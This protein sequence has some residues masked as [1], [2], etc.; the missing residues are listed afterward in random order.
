MKI[1]RNKWK[2]ILLSIIAI[3]IIFE[4]YCLIS[5]FTKGNL[6]IYTQANSIYYNNSN[7]DVLVDVVDK[8]GKLINSKI[9]LQLY[10]NDGKKVKGAKQFLK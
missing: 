1:S 4:A 6:N 5:F 10:N 9:K 3:I 2:I 8:D 7:I